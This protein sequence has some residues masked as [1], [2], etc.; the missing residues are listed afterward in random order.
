MNSHGIQMFVVSDHSCPGSAQQLELAENLEVD[1]IAAASVE[2]NF[3][4]LHK[5]LAVSAVAFAAVGIV[6]VHSAV[7]AFVR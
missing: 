1:R 6:V 2:C 5:E 3:V 7:V 4:A